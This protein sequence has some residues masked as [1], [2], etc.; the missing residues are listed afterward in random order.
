M[1]RNDRAAALYRKGNS[2]VTFQV[3]VAKQRE[4]GC[5]SN[6]ATAASITEI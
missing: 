1:N 6:R 5:V 3:R 2:I 4:F